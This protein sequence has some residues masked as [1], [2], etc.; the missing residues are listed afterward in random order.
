[1][2]ERRTENIKLTDKSGNRCTL[3]VLDLFFFDML[4]ASIILVVLGIPRKDDPVSPG[5]LM[6]TYQ[7]SHSNFTQGELDILLDLEAANSVSN[8]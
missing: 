2:D 3:G 6:T 7:A 4:A 8:S 1:M 5:A